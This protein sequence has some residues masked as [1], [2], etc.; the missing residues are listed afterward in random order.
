MSKDG[1]LIASSGTCQKNITYTTLKFSK[2]SKDYGIICKFEKVMSTMWKPRSAL[3]PKSLFHQY[4][5]GL[6]NSIPKKCFL[7]FKHYTSLVQKV[8][9]PYSD[10]LNLATSLMK[11]KA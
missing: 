11:Y 10:F 7:K 8:N 4:F 3:S 6:K 9:N 2:V 1:V 5:N